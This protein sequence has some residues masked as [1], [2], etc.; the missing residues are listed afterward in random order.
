MNEWWS[1]GAWKSNCKAKE[2]PKWGGAYHKFNYTWHSF[3]LLLFFFSKLDSENV[4]VQLEV[5]N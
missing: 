2:Y 1:L 4:C 5:V 3:L